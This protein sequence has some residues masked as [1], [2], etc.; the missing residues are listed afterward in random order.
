MAALL[1]FAGWTSPCPA[2][3]Q[4]PDQ[5][6]L[7]RL[8]DLSARRLGV[9]VSYDD[10]ALKGRLTLRSPEGAAGALSD[11]ELWAL[12]GRALAEQGLTTVRSGDDRTLA[13]VKLAQA[14]QAARLERLADLAATDAASPVRPGFRRVLVPLQR[15]ST[16]DVSTALQLVLSKG[17]GSVAESEAAGMLVVADLTPALD[18]ALE[19]IARMDAE[20]GSAAVR[21]VAAR[22]VEAPRLATLAKQLAEKQKAAGGRELRGDV[23]VAAGGS[24]VLI[25][26]PASAVPA[27]EAILAIV[28][29][30][31]GVERRAY[32]AAGFG[33]RE[34]ANLLEQTVRAP[35]SGAA[36]PGGGASDDRWRVVVDEL[37]GTLLV[38]ATP[39]QHEQ[40]AQTIDRLAAMPAEGRRPVRTFRIRNRAVREVQQVVEDLLRAGALDA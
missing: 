5:L 20:G 3:T 2:Q 11:A 30:R 38:T 9:A 21:E 16:K 8:V 35:A 28:D 40:V 39:A 6:D 31:E 14:S 1:S 26:A 25:V 7:A 17:A 4:L 23:V 10:A 37:T 34:V 29:E 13:V 36:G 32:G 15:A 18:M 22:N 12:T 33:L 19:L 27:W 24:G